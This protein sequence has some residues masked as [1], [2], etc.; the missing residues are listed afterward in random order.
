M[1]KLLGDAHLQKRGNSFR[2]KI[3]HGIEQKNYVLWTYKKLRRCCQTTQP[4]K[5]VT[6]KKGD[7]PKGTVNITIVFY[8]SSGVWLKKYHD[9]FYKQIL[10]NGKIKYVKKITE[11]LIKNLPMHPMVLAAW[12]MD[13]GN[14]RDDCF[15][16]KLATQGFETKEEHELLCK[17]LA[18][19]NIIG[20]VNKHT[21]ASQQYY[22]N[23]PVETF[24]LLVNEIEQYVEE[25]PDMI[26][27]IER[28]N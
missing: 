22:I 25:I 24:H 19:W 12:Y 3:E 11:E 2:L 18:K 5:P 13:D 26:Y 15:S 23:L 8:T 6:S 14:L 10:V 17:Y 1:G 9:L 28:K 4:P 27:K 21:T 7:Q 16:G 20:K